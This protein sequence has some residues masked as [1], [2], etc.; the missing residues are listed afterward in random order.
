MTGRNEGLQSMLEHIRILVRRFSAL[1]QKR[2]LD[3]DLDQELCSHVELAIEENLRQGMSAEEA[4]SQAQRSLGGIEQTKE[5]YREQREL[6]Q[7]E[8]MV[9]DI[10]Y[11]LR[12]LAR[13]PSFTTVAV[14]SLALGIGANTA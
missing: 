12:M 3:E 10:R 11:G 2:R 5:I 7:I 6:P 1:F 13:S 8:T 14:L 9:Q 4:R